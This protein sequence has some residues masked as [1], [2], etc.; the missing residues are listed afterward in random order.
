MRLKSKKRFVICILLLFAICIEL[1]T[2]QWS[3]AQKYEDIKVSVIDYENILGTE[4]CL[5]SAVNGNENG[6][7]IILPETINNK[8]VDR[9]FVELEV[10]E[11]ESTTIAVA[12]KVEKDFAASE[13]LE[14]AITEVQSDTEV[15]IEETSAETNLEENIADTNLDEVVVEDVETEVNLGNEVVEENSPIDDNS[16]EEENPSVSEES[17]EENIVENVIDNNVVENVV[18]NTVTENT[19]D[20]TVVE[21]TINNTNEIINDDIPNNDVQVNTVKKSV[22]LKP[23]DIVYLTEKQ[24]EEK[25]MI[26]NVKYDTKNINDEILYNQVIKKIVD[27]IPIKISGYMPIGSDAD[28]YLVED[29]SLISTV[30]LALD[31]TSLL[32]TLFTVK[33]IN[34]EEL[35]DYE[36]YGE[37]LT[38]SIS[39]TD[40]LKEY[41]VLEIDSEKLVVDNAK[42]IA[43]MDERVSTISS[44][45]DEVSESSPVNTEAMNEISNIVQDEV[46][47]EFETLNIDTYALI[48][49]VEAFE[50]T[51][52]SIE[53]VEAG[54]TVWD[55]TVGTG[56]IAGDGTVDK[57]YLIIT[58]NDLA[59]L[60]SQVNNGTSYDGKYF[61]LVCDIDLNGNAW[62]PIGTYTTPFEGIF[63]GAGHSISN[64]VIETISSLSANT[65]YSYGVFGAIQGSST[66]A[67]IKN[68]EFNNMQIN[69]NT[70][71]ANSGVNVG[72][73]SG[74]MF[75]K[76][77]ISNV[78]VKGGSIEAVNDYTINSNTIR[79]LVGGITGEAINSATSTEDPGEGNRY[80]IQNCYVSL[81]IDTSSFEAQQSGNRVR[82]ANPNYTSQVSTG[83]IIGRIRNQNVWPEN[84]LVETEINAVGFIGPIFG[85][86]YASTSYTNQSNFNTL[87]NGN[88]AAGG[89]NLTMTS[90]Y[91][92]YN[93]NNKSFTSSATTGTTTGSTTYRITASLTSGSGNRATVNMG[94]IQGVNKGSYLSNDATMLSRFNNYYSDDTVDFVYI[95]S[96][97][98]LKR[99]LSVNVEETSE[100]IYQITV[101]DQ[102]AVGSYTYEW[103]VDG[104]LDTTKTGTVQEIINE[105][106]EADI[107]VMVLV[108]DG[109]Y[110]GAVKF[111]IP[112]IK[113]EVEFRV[114]YSD[115]SNIKVYASL[116]G[117]GVST[118]YFDIN[119][120][121]FEWFELDLAGLNT[122]KV[123]GAYTLTLENAE[124]GL[125]YVLIATNNRYNQMS[126]EG[127]VLVGDRLVVYVSYTNGNNNRLGDTPDTAVKTIDRAYELL[128]S[129]YSRN[130]NVIVVMGTYTGSNAHYD[131]A[132]DTNY[133]KHATLTGAYD[134]I[135][136]NTRLSMYSGT[137]T[138]RYMLGDT[139]FQYMEWY[140]GN[141]QL[142][143]YA[144]GYDLTMGEQVTMVSYATSNTN[145]GLLSARAPAVHIFCGWVRY[146]YA[147][148][149]RTNAEIVIKSGTYGRIILGGS[150]GTSSAS[151]LQQSTSRNFIGS[152]LQTDPYNVKV[153]VDIQNSTTSSAYDYDINLLV[154]GSAAGNIIGNITEEIKNGSVGRVLGGS[155]GDSSVKPNNWNYPINTFIGTTTINITGGTVTELYGGC[156]GRN[157]TAIGNGQNGTGRAC[158]SYFYG[159]IN[160]NISGGTI[161]DN[162]YG[163]GAGGV[164]GYH[165]NSTDEYK[166]RYG[167]GVDTNVNINITGGNIQSNIYGGGY[168]YTEYLTRN[169]ITQDGGALYGDSNIK[170]SGSPTIEGNIFAAGCGYNLTNLP[171]LA[172]MYGNSNITISG[173]PTITGQI[174]GG[175]AGINGLA[176][177]AKLVGTSTV[178]INSSLSTNVYG[179]GNIAQSEGTTNIFVNSGTHTGEIYGGGN[180]GIITG[181]SNVK[182][183]GG[184]N[185]G[186]IYGGGNQAT[187]TT[188][189]VVIDGGTNSNSIFGGGN[190]ASVTTS[191]VNINN[192]TNI[193]VF[194]GGNQATVSDGTVNINGGITEAVYGGSNSAGANKTTVNLNGGE[195]TTIYG[196]SN[197]TGNVGTTNIFATSGTA[198]T[199]YGGNNAGG[200]VTTSNIQVDGGNITNVYGGNNEG[201]TLTTSNVTINNGNLQNVFGGGKQA[202]STTSNIT[203]NG[204]SISDIYGGGDQ[205]EN[206]TSNVTVNSGIITNIYGGGNLAVNDISN[207]NINAGTITNI[208]GGGNQATIT[209]S[210]VEIHGANITNIYGGGNQAG[211][212]TTNLEIFSGSIENIFGG[213]NQSGNVTESNVITTQEE[214]KIPVVANNLYGGNNAGG[215]TTTPN[216]EITVGR[217]ENVYGGG[218]KA[219]V[220]TTNVIMSGGTI[221]NIYGG[222]NEAEVQTD[223]NLLITGGTIQN[224][225]Y[226]GGNAATVNGNTNLEMTGGTVEKNIYGGGNEGTV[227][228]NSVANIKDTV[229]KG[230][231]YGGGNGSTAIVKKNSSLTVQGNCIVGF[232]G[233]DT[234]NQGCVFAG[235]NAAATGTEISNDSLATINVAG[236]NI[237]GNVYGGANT[238][239]V[240]GKTDVNI[241]KETIS[242]SNVS[243]GYI[244]IYG[245]VFGGGEANASGSEI[246]DYNFVSVTDGID[247]NIDGKGY[248]SFKIEGSIFGSGNASRTTG[249]S[250]VYINNFGTIDA[251]QKN[252]SIQRANLVVMD[253][254]AMTLSGAK[255]RTNEYSNEFFTIS[256]IDEFKLKNNSTLFL[257]YGANLLQNFY[258]LVDENGVEKIATVKINEN[259][260]I[261]RNVDNRLYMLEGRN[262][263]IATNEGATAYGNVYGMTFFGLYT[264]GMSPSTSVGL[265]SHNFDNGDVI[266]NLG[267]F[268]ANS[269]IK[270]AHKYDEYGSSIHDYTV[271]GFYTN[272]NVNG[273][274]ITEYVGVTPEN[275][276]HYIWLVGEAVDVKIFELT[277]TASKYATLG[278]SEL[279]LDGFNEPNTKFV[280]AGF[281]AGLQEGIELV[282]SEEIPAIIEDE[283]EANTLFGLNMKNGKRGW[284]SENDNN[285]YTANNGSFDGN[286]TYKM[287]NT[288]R[289]PSLVFCLYHAQNLSREQLLGTV[290]IRFQVIERVDDLNDKISFADIN[291]TMLT[292]LYQ[293]DF[294]EAAI[295]PGEEFELFTTTE[296]NITNDGEFSVY[297]SLYIPEF[298]EN[299][300]YENY[301]T[302][303]RCIV[304]RKL[305][306]SNYVFK[307]NTRIVM[308]DLVTNTTYY[309][310]VTQED[311]NNGKIK[312]YLKD[313]I[314][315]GTTNEKYN[316]V[317]SYSD[318]YN[319]NQDLIYENYIFHVNFSEADINA[320]SLDNTLLMELHDE[321]DETLLG[322]LGIQRE[323]TKYSI[324]SG[325]E[326]IISADVSGIPEILYV[327]N[328]FEMDVKTNF[329]QLIVNTK[330]VYDTKYFGQKVGIKITMFDVN[331]NQLN[332]DSLLGVY[333]ELDGQ[334]YYPRIDGSTRIYV[335]DRLSNVLSEIK[336]DTSQN[337]TLATGK[338]TIKIETFAS[339]DGVYYGLTASDYV[340]QELYIINGV[341]GLKITTSDEEKIFNKATGKNQNNVNTLTS[342]L[343]YSS[344]LEKPMITV[345]LERR[346]YSSVYSEDYVQ[347]DLKD[348]INSNVTEFGDTNEYIVS[349]APTSEIVYTLGLRNNLMTGTYRLVYKLYDETNYIGEVYEYLIIR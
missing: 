99:R 98:S 94:Y 312:F 325:K 188:T 339:S 234:P 146:N 41:K 305:D 254:S 309:Y 142:Y 193:N 154:G 51:S 225:I 78:I 64:G 24:L 95:N 152:N 165:A 292:D 117:S 145:Q 323:T 337:T 253:N 53:N 178:T 125:E 271:D 331:G 293:D 232:V 259:G 88:D 1:I 287:E 161:V 61:Q 245:T 299:D 195:V 242:D 134:G 264:N 176:N 156:L 266:T 93:V 196:G 5:W 87:W 21:N 26:V 100:F 15:K 32:S 20:N 218:N 65:T 66:I 238:S 123:E 158:D 283:E 58:G 278:T 321:N 140:G 262:L 329:E 281:S 212:T 280:I 231:I 298:S 17:T 190:Q 306:E 261:E 174:F 139:T 54:G 207:V 285:F 307:A 192:G 294:Y 227:E 301:N 126:A 72:I 318:Y 29:E 74:T 258:S 103:Y 22:E 213:S 324:Y 79:L 335:A 25:A 71:R 199:I 47:I 200:K 277:L 62:T 334:R 237:Y 151:N 155:I 296:T 251:P 313:F 141:N 135:D 220:S 30:E 91:S 28:V 108:S 130:E 330:T 31:Q 101:E 248:D 316:S 124:K 43:L 327:G 168:G 286:E 269:Y 205:A 44:S 57:P 260:T 265:Y 189:N 263:N 187:V 11:T 4:D 105:S 177:M 343:E 179:G 111:T 274:A 127:K 338:Y 70:L 121:S 46:S 60:A 244:Y 336:V 290:K 345:S 315:M 201:G 221:T 347:V 80:S 122:T 311:E 194:A 73:V 86:V 14:D 149:P 162:I 52:L 102:Y 92:G 317:Q 272:R 270:G 37:K 183:S 36:K 279:V 249:R 2:F 308:L 319:S 217:I 256:R 252:I 209:T 328:S 202:E 333:F 342:N 67:E 191:T 236:G 164:T 289:A 96:E 288:T 16:S 167:S 116:V 9:Y 118:R 171:N 128:N 97:F 18:D 233:C 150:P 275:D 136:Y 143:F 276:L 226:G 210:N 314:K 90:Y 133:Q 144:Q 282:N 3:K 326:A 322:V 198:T 222:G 77:K 63:D 34:G 75:A 349:E 230:S 182:I 344:T 153:I 12:G 132:T 215:I 85:S 206:T 40:K 8:V 267:T 184:T 255:D 208:Y 35:V 310:I 239:I 163:A 42:K 109:Q 250:E 55:G 76:T 291:I 204:G 170:I 10:P 219:E 181:T 33:I 131:S 19:I 172:Q 27:D 341:Y 49:E 257:N 81:T 6:Y 113:V 160:I 284:I 304:S 157:M 39:G 45:I 166:D 112:R 107:I 120:Y 273:I 297:Y 241:G 211:A 13:T 114:D 56:F 180:V 203:I 228:K 214:G 340:E 23:G 147:T 300:L 303:E 224:S 104:I 235:G 185:T 48:E 247:V 175:G 240:Y 38:I 346:S 83:G 110:Y 173:S 348:Y 115:D 129:N 246:Y 138:Y 84:C 68:T 106:F 69:I 50:S 59:Y 137:S 119:D 82:Y 216:I 243:I 186:N 295:T 169:V 89:N 229:V 148:L 268:S 7:Y 302:Y 159:D 197:L 332:S 223:A 320:N